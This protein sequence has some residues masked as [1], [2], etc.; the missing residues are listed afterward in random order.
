MSKSSPS[1]P[2]LSAEIERFLDRLVYTCSE[3][4][5][6]STRQG[7]LRDFVTRF[8]DAYGWD[9]LRRAARARLSNSDPRSIE[10][11]LTCLFVVGT[12]ND[13]SAVEH[14]TTHPDVDVQKAARTCLFAIQHGAKS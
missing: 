9:A 11:R 14:L 6:V 10:R 12:S 3:P 2:D 4:A 1:Q 13:L 8:A 7:F 5:Y